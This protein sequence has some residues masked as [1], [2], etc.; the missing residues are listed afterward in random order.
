[1]AKR[2]KTVSVRIYEETRNAL[3]L[4]QSRMRADQVRLGLPRKKS[5]FADLIAVALDEPETRSRR[6]KES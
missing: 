3:L 6:A 1:M 4:V 2:P 5:R